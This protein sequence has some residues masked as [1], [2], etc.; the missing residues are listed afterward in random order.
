MASAALSEELL[1]ELG[2]A[3]DLP[4]EPNEDFQHRRLDPLR[5]AVAK[6][7]FSNH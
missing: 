5:M 3:W 7:L 4:P 6:K 1:N 2:G